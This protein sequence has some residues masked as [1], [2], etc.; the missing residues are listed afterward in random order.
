MFDSTR[1]S[2]FEC[3][4]FRFALTPSSF[5]GG[6]VSRSR[7]PANVRRSVATVRMRCL[8]CGLFTSFR[9]RAQ[10]CVFR[11]VACAAAGCW[12]E[13]GC[14]MPLV[15]DS[16][17]C[18]CCCG[19]RSLCAWKVRRSFAPDFERGASSGCIKFTTLNFTA[20][21]ARACVFRS[22]VAILRWLR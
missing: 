20:G 11:L 3:D 17:R 10:R 13:N 19:G 8:L 1:C 22:C 5:R 21:F 2:R 18:D 16:M 15:I 12:F 14:Q 6:A 9:S 4:V 7:W